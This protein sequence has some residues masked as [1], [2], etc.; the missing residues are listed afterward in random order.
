[1]GNYYCSIILATAVNYDYVGY[2]VVDLTIMNDINLLMS[3][4]VS[5]T[6]MFYNTNTL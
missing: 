1:M 3:L 5:K 6:F 4:I 2:I